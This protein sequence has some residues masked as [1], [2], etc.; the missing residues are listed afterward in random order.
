MVDTCPNCKAHLHAGLRPWHRLCPACSYEGSTLEPGILHQRA[1]GDLDEAARADALQPL[2]QRNFQRVA[3]ELRGLVTRGSGAPTLLDVGC[4][5]GWFLAAA[6]GLG[7]RTFGLE[8]DPNVVPVGS[9]PDASIR[10][11]FFPDAIEGHERFDAISFNDVLEHIADIDRAVGACHRH[12][13]DGGVLVVNAPDRTGTLYRISKLMARFGMN[14]TFGRMWQEGFPSPHLHYLDSTWLVALMGRH[15]FEL[16]SSR[17]LPSVSLHG[18]YERVSF[19]GT[20]SLR[21]GLL[22]LA[23]GASIPLLAL[24]PQDIRVWYFRRHP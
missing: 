14:G 17:T 22:T 5:H 3:A 7:F 8:P 16:E 10:S 11:G 18:L 24:L 9:P 23:I 20:S 21:A 4:A 12:L 6:S 15:G 13:A 2:R 1:G 19:D